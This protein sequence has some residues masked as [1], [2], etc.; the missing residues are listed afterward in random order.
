MGFVGDIASEEST[1][2]D[3]SPV[4]SQ[5]HDGEDPLRGWQGCGHEGDHRVGGD[6]P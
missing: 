3:R 6:P 2:G 5:E 4:L 1:A